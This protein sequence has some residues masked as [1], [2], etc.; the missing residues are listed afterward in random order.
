MQDCF[1]NHNLTD[2][3]ISKTII[4]SGNARVF[5]CVKGNLIA[6]IGTLPSVI[7]INSNIEP[8]LRCS[9]NFLKP[10][11]CKVLLFSWCAKDNVFYG[12]V[13]PIITQTGLI[14]KTRRRL[15]SIDPQRTVV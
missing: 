4:L 11:H 13:T 7:R 12:D 9:C 1:H 10:F 8:S 6:Q 3:R 14:K 5:T 15:L 2:L